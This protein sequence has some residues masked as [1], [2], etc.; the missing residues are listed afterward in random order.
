MSNLST[1]RASASTYVIPND[2]GRYNILLSHFG[3]GHRECCLVRLNVRRTILRFSF[4]VPA[5]TAMVNSITPTTKPGIPLTGLFAGRGLSGG[6]IGL[7]F[8]DFGCCWWF[9]ILQLLSQISSD[10]LVHEELQN[11]TLFTLL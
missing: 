6:R 8:S 10:F 4:K 9:D 2:H 11:I 3:R 7:F 1:R 5:G